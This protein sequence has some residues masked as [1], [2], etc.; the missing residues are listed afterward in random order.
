MTRGSEDVQPLVHPTRAAFTVATLTSPFT[1][2][3]HSYDGLRELPTLPLPAQTS[4]HGERRR[5][6]SRGRLRTEAATLLEPE[7][8]R[9]PTTAFVL[10][11]SRA[12]QSRWRRRT[13]WTEPTPDERIATNGTDD[14][15]LVADD[16]RVPRGPRKPGVPEARV[17]ASRATEARAAR[18]DTTWLLGRVA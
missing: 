8:T 12:S 6:G 9:L 1:N 18:G 17:D 7:A 15:R 10:S 14:Q 4:H 11:P 2:Q 5:D 3:Q 16:S 13:R